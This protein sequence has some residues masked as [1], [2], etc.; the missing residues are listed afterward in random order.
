MYNWKKWYTEVDIPPVKVDW[1]KLGSKR[2][3][4]NR[5]LKVKGWVGLAYDYQV[6]DKKL[7]NLNLLHL[8]SLLIHS[9]NILSLEVLL[10]LSFM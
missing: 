2:Q 9:L 1:S 7:F 5:N 6:H 10:F 4:F 3:Q 8:P